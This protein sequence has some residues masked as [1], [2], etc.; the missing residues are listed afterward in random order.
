MTI[1]QAKRT[2][3]APMQATPPIRMTARAARDAQLAALGLDRPP[4]RRARKKDVIAAIR[5]MHILQI[6]TIH[7]VARSPYLVLWSRLGDYQP[8]WLNAHLADGRLFEYWAHEASFLPV[9]DYPLLRHRMIDPGS[10]G[11]KYSHEWVEENRDT[12]A[13][14]LAAVREHGPMRS[15]DFERRDGKGGAWWGWKPEKRALEMLLTSGHLMV[16]K[17]QNFQRVYDL[18][19][20]V[21]PDWDEALLPD[22]ETA[23]RALAL[24]ATQALGVATARWIA[25]YYRVRPAENARRVAALADEGA[26]LRIDVAGWSEPAYAHPD[27]LELIERAIDNRI[28]P[29][30][31]T[32]LSPFDPLVWDRRRALTTFNFDYRLECYTPE[33]KRV[34][35]YFTLPILHRGRIVGRLDPKAHRADGRMEIRSIHLEDDVAPSVQLAQ[36]LAPT[37]RAFAAWH[38]TPDVVIGRSAPA[39]FARMLRT[40]LSA[41]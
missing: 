37:L 1:H 13:R 24:Q 25:D 30:H 28:R 41:G 21:L 11:W 10:M 33:P 17:R 6:D 4:R 20:R 8:R 18:R 7:V 3:S 34:Y 12:V 16:R 9:E 38:E 26:L 40:A 23:E 35:G 39:G 36:A 22:R 27:N 2:R 15:A 31:T 19:E 5:A 32:L 29:R 14:V